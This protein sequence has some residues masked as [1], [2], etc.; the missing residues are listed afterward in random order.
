MPIL[1]QIGPS[2]QTTVEFLAEGICHDDLR[3]QGDIKHSG[4]ALPDQGQ[5]RGIRQ[6]H[7]TVLRMA[8]QLRSCGEHFVLN[9]V[10]DPDHVRRP[11]H[12]RSGLGRRRM[13]QSNVAQRQ[14]IHWGVCLWFDQS[15]LAP[16]GVVVSQQS[17]ADHVPPVGVITL[18][19]EFDDRLAA[20]HH[21][22][23]GFLR[24]TPEELANLLLMLNPQLLEGQILVAAD[25]V[26]K[27]TY[28]G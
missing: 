26:R 6:H 5:G 11:L 14:L 23:H 13:L 25:G 1:M 20:R 28:G 9:N 22:S 15:V 19:A 3:I 21:L 27:L 16:L 2:H 18:K 8:L 7:A 17:P 12:D 24:G 10:L 4:S